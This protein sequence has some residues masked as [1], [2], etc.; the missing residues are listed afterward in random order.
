MNFDAELATRAYIDG[1]G[2]EALAQASAYTSG[3]QWLMLWSLF[4]AMVSTWLIVRSG[5]LTRLSSKLEK[6]SLFSRA[7]TISTSFIVIS[8]II[9]LPWK[10]YTDWYRQTSYN[11]TSQPLVDFLSQ[12]ALGLA[13]NAVTLGLLLAIFYLVIKKAG[14]LCGRGSVVS[15]RVLSRS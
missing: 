12:S 5:V 3:N 10:V 7:F 1:L 15:R 9:E 11:M 4:V 8:A 14:Q 13:I 2:E 6:S